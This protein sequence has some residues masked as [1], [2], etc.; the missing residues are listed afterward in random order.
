MLAS[1]IITNYNYGRYIGRC[2]R[3]CLNQSLTAKNYEIIIIDDNSS[4]N[5]DEVVKP[6]LNH[7]NIK[8]IKNR[9]NIGVAASANKG[10]KSAKGKYVVRVDADDY[11][12]ENFLNFLVY[13]L[14]EYP[15]YFCVSCDY[16]LVNKQEKKSIVVSAKQYPVACGI[17]Y[18][19]NKLKKYNF[20]NPKFRHR[21]EEELR[22][23]IA[24][25]YKIHNLNIPLYRYQIHKKNKTFE[26]DYLNSYKKKIE[27]INNKKNV[28]KINKNRALLKKDILKNVIAIIP[29]RGGSKR[30]K[31]KNMY[32]VWGKPMIFWTINEAKKS[33]YINDIYV[34]SEDK[35]IKEFSIENNVKLINRPA[36]LSLD[37][38]FKMEAIKHAV[39]IVEKYSKPTL[40]V[41][42][43]AN[44]PNISYLDID[45]AINHLIKF[46]RSEVISVD[47]DYNQ[48]G[49][50]R[51]MR[52]DSVFQKSLSTDIGIIVTK[53][54]DV[55]TKKDLN[56][57]EE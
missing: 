56:K 17:M 44:S 10:F 32:K 49:A 46:N 2:L 27:K 30:F 23:R 50:I 11:V 22:L 39:K 33:I 14:K 52:Y 40:I 15:E 47:E 16:F 4:D 9:K 35:K 41:S 37:K 38:V 54:V 43:Q 20:Y 12:N 21:E 55:H 5:T 57:L 36:K 31:K 1:I 24:Q 25:N 53:I 34:T 42:L 6:F 18:V 28:T 48:N 3:S 26:N 7:S 45:K 13:Y 8:Y 29:A 51:V 19:K